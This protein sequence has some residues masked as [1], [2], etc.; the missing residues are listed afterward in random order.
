MNALLEKCDLTPEDLL[1]LGDNG[2]GLELVDG[3]LVEVNVSVL[4]DLVANL[5][6]HFLTAHCLA[7]RLGHVFSSDAPARRPRPSRA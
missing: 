4:A 7:N 5:L 3:R 1:R 2:K 6:C